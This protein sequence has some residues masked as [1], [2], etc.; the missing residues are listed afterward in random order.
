[1]PSTDT[2]P[3]PGLSIGALSRATGVAVETL[4]TWERRYGYPSSERSEGGH[5]LYAIDTIA[6]VRL[7]TQALERGHRVSQ[8]VSLDEDALLA[9][10]GLGPGEP[11]DEPEQ[12]APHTL[13]R[14]WLE[15]SRAMDAQALELS[16]R[17]AWYTLG[18]VT[19][20]ER[21]AARFIDE[22][23]QAWASGALSVG[24]EHFASERLRDFFTSHWRPLSD[25]ATGP[26][27]V[28]ATLPHELHVLGLHMVAVIMA[29]CG[30]RVLFLGADTPLE[31]IVSA[32]QS[33]GADAL[34][35]SLSCAY[36]KGVAAAHMEQLRAQ[37]ARSCTIVLGGSG[38]PPEFAH[39]LRFESLEE[40]SR[41]APR[42][43]TRQQT[44]P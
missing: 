42:L 33:G 28:C 40:L 19:F 7:I 39:G 35:I 36:D 38:A 26:T 37:V 18:A 3:F 23:G 34:L 31:S 21:Y 8:V 17:R 13:T 9:L 20:L 4:R 32:C 5:R 30:C 22:I 43:F 14:E 12:A 10:L 2:P 44:S 15:L 16:L 25:R 41:W 27:V 24:Q 6:R 1:M 29:I 11:Q